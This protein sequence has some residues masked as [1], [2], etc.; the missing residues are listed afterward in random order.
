MAR[1]FSKTHETQHEVRRPSTS[2]P[3]VM[4]APSD[5]MTVIEVVITLAILSILITM[6]VGPGQTVMEA[7]TG[8]GSSDSRAGFGRPVMETMMPPT[9][10]SPLQ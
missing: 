3:R 7:G 8:S 5:G 4:T 10:A 1:T 9:T 6:G 2:L